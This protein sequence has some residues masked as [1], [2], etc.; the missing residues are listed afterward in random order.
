MFDF[1][2]I[3]LV[4]MRMFMVVVVVMVMMMM[5]V[6]G[7]MVV[8]VS[9]VN[10]KFNSGNGRFLPARNVEVPTFELELLEFALELPGVHAEIEQR[11]DKHVA[12][13]AADEVE[14]KRLH[15]SRNIQRLTFNFQ[16]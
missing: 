2:K 4:F 6:A 8:V 5:I 11:G 1:G 9:D 13:D 14:V 15:T 12:G 3:A 16:R 10:I 7:F